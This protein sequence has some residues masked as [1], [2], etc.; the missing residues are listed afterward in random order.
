MKTE[1]VKAPE[2]P[3]QKHDEKKP[4]VKPAAVVEEVAQV[5][6]AGSGNFTKTDGATCH[7]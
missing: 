3:Q 1:D 2:T 7:S 4:W 5:T 6:K